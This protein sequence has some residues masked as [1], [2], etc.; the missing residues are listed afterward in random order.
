M[1]DQ[2]HRV[3]HG[4]DHDE[5]RRRHQERQHDAARIG[6]AARAFDVRGFAQILR[7]GLERR[8]IE[9]HEETGFLPDRHDND[10]PECRIRMAEPVDGR[11]AKQAADLVEYAKAGRVEE[12]PQIGGSDHRQD[13]RREIS[14]AHEAARGNL[15][16][17][18]Q[19]HAE[20]DADRDR[21][22]RCGIDQIVLNDRPEGRVIEQR[23]IVFR[24]DKFGRATTRTAREEARPEGRDRRIECE[25]R[26]QDTRREQEQPAIDRLSAPIEIDA[27]GHDGFLKGAHRQIVDARWFLSSDQRYG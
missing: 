16:V 11:Q 12:Q 6:P 19:G 10:G 24:A 25:Q 22:R 1:V 21:N 5:Q 18:P 27:A 13:G 26:K 15:G 8:E 14:G 17:G 2:L 3:D 9:D 20:R 7:D 23:G 4:I